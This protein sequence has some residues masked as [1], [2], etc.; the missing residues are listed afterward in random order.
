MRFSGSFSVGGDGRQRL[1]DGPQI[2]DAD[3]LFDQ[4][5]QDV[6][7]Q[8]K[9]TGFGTVAHRGGRDL[10][11]LVEQPLGLGDAQEIGGARAQ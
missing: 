5:T 6:G 4:A 9:L 3:P 1:E 11:E 8:R 7:E 2:A 10:L